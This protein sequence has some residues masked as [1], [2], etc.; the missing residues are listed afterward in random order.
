MASK[1]NKW[2]GRKGEIQFRRETKRYSDGTPWGKDVLF[3]RIAGVECCHVEPKEIP[4]ATYAGKVWFSGVK[5]TSQA[6]TP[7]Q[8]AKAILRHLRQCQEAA[9][10]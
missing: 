6:L 7:V 2:R 4:G 9:N 5:T 10:A 8:A 1:K 3:I